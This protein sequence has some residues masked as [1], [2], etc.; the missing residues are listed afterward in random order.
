VCCIVLKANSLQ[1]QRND[2][3]LLTFNEPDNVNQ[4]NLS[5]EEAASLWPKIVTIAEENDLTIVSPGLTHWGDGK[6]DWLDQFIGNVSNVMGNNEDKLPFEYISVHDYS[7]NI[8]KILDNADNAFEKYGVQIWL[9][10]FAKGSGA[11]RAKNMDFMKD[12]L[13]KLEESDSVNRYAWYEPSPNDL[14]ETNVRK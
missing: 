5:P 2:R 7:G 10:E 11:G 9:T 3:Y 14:I 6:W 12:A 1:Q 13:V 4:S 8:E